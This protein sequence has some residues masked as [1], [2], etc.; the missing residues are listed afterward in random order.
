[1][2]GLH[3]WLLWHFEREASDASLA[4]GSGSVSN[5]TMWAHRLRGISGDEMLGAYLGE[6]FAGLTSGSERVWEGR[7]VAGR[8][9]LVNESW[10]LYPRDDILYWILYF[11][12]G[13]CFDDCDYDTRPPFDEIVEE[14]IRAIP[15][16][17]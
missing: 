3:P 16:G 6:Q 1:M 7:E 8:R 4:L 11:D 12:F 9:Y 15:S 13:D 14:A 10:A 17:D 5:F 2:G